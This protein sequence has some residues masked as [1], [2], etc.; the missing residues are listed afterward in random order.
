MRN[1]ILLV[2]VFGLYYTLHNSPDAPPARGNDTILIFRKETI[3]VKSQDSLI[4]TPAAFGKDHSIR[5]DDEFPDVVIDA[6]KKVVK[7]ET[8]FQVMYCDTLGNYMPTFLTTLGSGSGFIFNDS[9]VGTADHNINIKD[10]LNRNG[11]KLIYVP[12][13]TFVYTPDGRVFP[14]TVDSCDHH[15]DI[16][17]LSLGEYVHLDG[18]SLSTQALKAFD[19]LWIAGYPN[20]DNGVIPT[21]KEYFFD[22]QDKNTA[23]SEG[24]VGDMIQE[25][26]EKVMRLS[27][28]SVT[29]PGMSGGPV[30]NKDGKVVG[31]IVAI[32]YPAGNMS[33]AVPVEFF[34]R[35]IPTQK[36]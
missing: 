10:E 8:T 24:L 31:V 36:K 29:A 1:L 15:N 20:G 33:Y 32:D 30:L 4:N 12:I 21:R 6:L 9:L 35:L 22:I 5:N 14:A 28:G 17:V 13:R 3:F 18:F 11:S 16:A 19:P 25:G 23:C 27:G 2:C 26:Y 34:Q 7:I